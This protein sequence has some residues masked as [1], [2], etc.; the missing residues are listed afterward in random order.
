MTIGVKAVTNLIQKC[1]QQIVGNRLEPRNSFLFFPLRVFVFCLFLFVCLFVFLFL[2][3]VVIEI[4][5]IEIIT[6]ED[7]IYSFDIEI[8]TFED[9]IYSHIF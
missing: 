7:L 2:F 6:F 9:L 3:F 4:F 1:K 8:I 5:E